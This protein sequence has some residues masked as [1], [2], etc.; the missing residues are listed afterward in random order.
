MSGRSPTSSMTLPY[1]LWYEILR[2]A[3]FIPREFDVSTTTFRS[4][5]VLG[6]D[7]RHVR[8]YRKVLPTRVAVVN[9]CRI[10]HRIG[11]EFLYGSVHFISRGN[12]VGNLW[13]HLVLFKMLLE[14]RP[15]LGTL[16]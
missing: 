8:V 5:L 10:W 6:S 4:G 15:E 12:T 16:V 13:G 7:E 9:V 14:S 2:E 11:T 1:E 3:T